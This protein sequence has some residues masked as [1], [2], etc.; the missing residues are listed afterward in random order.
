MFQIWVDVEMHVLLEWADRW[1]RGGLWERLERQMGQTV[2]D[3]VGWVSDLGFHPAC[4]QVKSHSL[5]EPADK[6][7]MI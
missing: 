4:M 3:L 1:I 6:L 2:Q 7:C 5:V